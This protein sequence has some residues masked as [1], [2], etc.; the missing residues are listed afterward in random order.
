MLLWVWSSS[1]IDD[2]EQVQCIFSAGSSELLAPGVALA[3]RS[4]S[5]PRVCIELCRITSIDPSTFYWKKRNVAFLINYPFVLLKQLQISVVSFV[6]SKVNLTLRILL[7]KS[8]ISKMGRTDFIQLTEPMTICDKPSIMKNSIMALAIRILLVC[9]QPT[10][11][12]KELHGYLSSHSCIST[13]QVNLVTANS[14]SSICCRHWMK[15]DQE[16][17]ITEGLNGYTTSV[18][19]AILNQ[20]RAN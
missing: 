2:E 11:V 8:Q 10:R 13:M 16:K 6:H 18:T 14:G 19:I 1:T 4:K 17:C 5:S 9:F 7:C 12:L 15:M 20:C 3:S